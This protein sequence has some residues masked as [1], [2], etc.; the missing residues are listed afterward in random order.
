M[1]LDAARED[2]ES[3]AHRVY[4]H[5]DTLPMS[6][7]VIATYP[8]REPYSHSLAGWLGIILAVLGGAAIAYGTTG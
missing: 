3:E 4:S 5:I 8:K 6:D 1:I 2:W 7:G